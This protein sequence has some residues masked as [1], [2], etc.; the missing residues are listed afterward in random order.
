MTDPDPPARA[1]YT[2]KLRDRQKA[3]T[4][5]LI[6]AS[7][8]TILNR[9]GLAAVT[10][11]EVAQTAEVTERTVYRHFSTR[12]ELLKAFWRWQLEQ[13]GGERVTDPESL[14]ALLL[15]V[16]R[17][18][19]SLDANEG[20]VRAMLAS[21]EGRDLRLQTNRAR[22]AHM[23]A[24]VSTLLPD[25]PEAE[26]HSLAAGIVVVCS[27]MSWMFMRDHCGF[28]GARAGDASAYAVRLMI[29][30]ARRRHH[31]EAA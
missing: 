23:L 7:V 4:R 2:S 27:V 8:A 22:Y 14:E 26:R 17:L 9:D 6:L 13:A 3:E 16:R 24:F 20:V 30:A 1:G 10:I 19:A 12:E 28:D 31:S 15:T 18:F 25:L 29:E 21:S 5:T 11:A